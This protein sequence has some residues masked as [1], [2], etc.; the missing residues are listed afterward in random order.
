M[1]KFAVFGALVAALA[2]SAPA[3]AA[4]IPTRGP[5]YKAAPAPVFNWT[6]FYVGAHIGYGFG[7]DTD[8]SGGLDMDGIFGGAQ[9]GYN[10]QFARNWVFGIEADISA[11]DIN[12]NALFTNLDYFGTV[13]ARLGYTW[14][15]T[16]LYGTGG[17]AFGD[18][19]ILGL[20]NSHTGYAVGAGLEWA[21]A[22]NWSAKV[23]YLYV[24]FSDEFYGILGNAGLDFHTVKF[25][26]NYRFGWR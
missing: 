21:F 12:D 6:G 24:D 20:T 10:W 14:D 13:R 15:R 17:F 25:G 26:V 2:F 3:T 7:G 5:I 11:S 8:P 19:T 18:N 16:M 22:P 1:K 4:D 9:L 23:E